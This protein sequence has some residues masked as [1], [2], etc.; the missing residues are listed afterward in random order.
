L[1]SYLRG[2]KGD[3]SL[4]RAR[5]QEKDQKTELTTEAQSSNALWILKNSFSLFFPAFL[6][7]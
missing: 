4:R 2:E 5:R 7:S 3:E 6:S 1:K